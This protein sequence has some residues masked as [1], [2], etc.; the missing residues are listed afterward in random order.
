MCKMDKDL[1]EI[2]KMLIDNNRKEK[3]IKK[4]ENLYNYLASNRDD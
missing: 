3:K 4:L 2:T 1:V